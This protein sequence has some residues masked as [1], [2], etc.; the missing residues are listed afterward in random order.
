MTFIGQV[1]GMSV[2]ENKVSRFESRHHYVLS[3]S[4]AHFRINAVD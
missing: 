3:L 1:H 2:S 4:K